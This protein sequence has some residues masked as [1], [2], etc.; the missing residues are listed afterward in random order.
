MTLALLV[1]FCSSFY[2]VFLSTL[3]SGDDFT[4]FAVWMDTEE[5]VHDSISV[6]SVWNLISR[7]WDSAKWLS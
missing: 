6:L 5:Y 2:A 4:V 7:S 3:Q 1:A